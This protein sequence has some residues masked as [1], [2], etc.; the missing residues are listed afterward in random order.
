MKLEFCSFNSGSNGNTSYVAAGNTRLLIDAGPPGRSIVGMLEQIKVLV[1]LETINGILV[2]HEHSDH[3][4]G[5]GVLSRK[6]HIPIYANEAT[7]QAMKR[8]VGGASHLRRVFETGVGLAVGTSGCFPFLFPMTQWS[9]WLS[10]CMPATAAWR[11][12]LDMGRVS[13]TNPALPVRNRPDSA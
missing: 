4:K 11:W 1:L 3:V 13:K 6:F 10:G 9:R 5:V 7:W 12:P 8:T 2:T